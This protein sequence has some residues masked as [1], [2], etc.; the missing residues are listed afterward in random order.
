MVA[1]KL[2]D[3]W[4]SMKLS[5]KQQLFIEEYLIDLN[6]T[7]AAIRAGYNPNT[8]RQIAAENLTKPYIRKA[9]DK[10]IAD[11]SR[12]TGINQ[13]RVILELARLAFVNPLDV[14]NLN[15]ATVYGEANRD[16]VAAIASVKVKTMYAPKGK[17][18]EREVRF[19]NKLH[20]LELIGKHLGMWKDSLMGDVDITVTIIDD[21][22]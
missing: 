10:A 18:I 7:Q 4:R 15:D 9:I 21:L 6:G 2:E 12:R 20:A 22:E 8:A 13:D 3:R 1:N 14:I 16:D 5:Q 19:Y 11:R 17:V